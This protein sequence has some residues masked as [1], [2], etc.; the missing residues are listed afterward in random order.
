M[1]LGISLEPPKK[2][3]TLSDLEKNKIMELLKLGLNKTDI[4]KRLGISRATL[5][6]KM[7]EYGL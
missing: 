1:S 4:S 7:G 5:Y 3:Q 2:E 6:R